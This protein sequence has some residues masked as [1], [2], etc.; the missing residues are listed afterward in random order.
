M[1]YKSFKLHLIILGLLMLLGSCEKPSYPENSILGA[2]MSF[3][4]NTNRQYNVSI[5]YFGTDS[6]TIQLINFHNLGFGTETYA[7]I[8]DTLITL[9]GTNSFDSFSGT[10][11]VER[12]FSAIYWKYSYSGSSFSDPQVD[13]L[14][15][16]Y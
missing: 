10:G 3:E 6:S 1:H 4:Y 8:S 14:F 9:I 12:D 7:T 13:A 2:W 5:D 15:R 16:R 11:H